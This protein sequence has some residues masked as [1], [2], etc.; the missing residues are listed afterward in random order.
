MAPLILEAAR[1]ARAEAERLRRESAELKLPMQRN[2]DPP[3]SPPSGL[4]WV[5]EDD[6]L[7]QT[8]VLLD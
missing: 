4:R 7:E 1:A 5:H 3:V 2:E 6:S 8:L